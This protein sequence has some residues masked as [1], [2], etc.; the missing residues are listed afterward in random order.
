M[1]F[2]NM[3]AAGQQSD[4]NTRHWLTP[5][6]FDK[7]FERILDAPNWEVYTKSY[8]LTDTKSLHITAY[9]GPQTTFAGSIIPA[10][11][12]QNN[13]H[14]VI[15]TADF[16]LSEPT[17]TFNE[18]VSGVVDVHMNA[19][20][21]PNDPT[22]LI[23][24]SPCR[25]AVISIEQDEFDALPEDLDFSQFLIDLINTGGERLWNANM[26]TDYSIADTDL[27][28]FMVARM[29]EN[30]TGSIASAAYGETWKV[31]LTPTV[32]EPLNTN[33]FDTETALRI[34]PNPTSGKL[35]IDSSLSIEQVQVY[36]MAGQAVG[37]FE[38]ASEI[39]LSNYTSG[40]YLFQIYGSD[41]SVT[42]E[43]VVKK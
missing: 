14:T 19:R 33:E 21:D 20:Y 30:V 36:N 13:Y 28:R 38:N 2:T 42:L 5:R 6:A 4:P 41:G 7:G 17:M 25:E 29:A 12:G 40:I 26:G 15:W 34:Y 9:Q 22:Q 8:M 23:D 16:D 39:D 37:R 18:D 10:T 27:N 35:A 31:F 43:K 24:C 3:D 1:V 11:S 32:F